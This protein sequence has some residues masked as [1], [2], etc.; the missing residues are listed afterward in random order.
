M[1]INIELTEHDL[2]RLVK[3]YIEDKTG[4]KVGDG[5]ILIQTKSA[6]NYKSEW[7][8]ANF[9]ATYSTIIKD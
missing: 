7:E 8:T 6:Q 4:Q 2:K 1:Q 9:K 5:Q 3:K